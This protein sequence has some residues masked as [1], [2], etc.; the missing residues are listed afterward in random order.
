MFACFP[1][2]CEVAARS[3]LG[4]TDIDQ[5]IYWIQLNYIEN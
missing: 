3:T 2:F 4:D 1:S 5:H